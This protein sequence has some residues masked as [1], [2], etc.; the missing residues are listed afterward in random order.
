MPAKSIRGAGILAAIAVGMLVS[1]VLAGK[2]ARAGEVVD[3]VVARVEGDILLL[4]D[5]RELGQFQLLSG[6]KPEPASKRLE[7]LIDQWMI[8]R[9]AR[10]AR[11]EEPAVE[12]ANT[13][14]DQMQKEL[15]G[16]PVFAA[17]LAELGL[18]AAAVR[19]LLRR[20]IFF[21]RYLDYKFRPAVQVDEA[22]ERKYYDDELVPQM[23]ARGEKAPP[24][25][26]VR[27]QIQE[28]LVQRDISARAEKW[29]V[30]S[31]ARLKVEVV[32]PSPRD[33]TV[34]PG[35]ELISPQ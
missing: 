25:D 33:A 31:R 3:R 32:P 29:L 27:K 14:F 28:L 20:A 18:S 5:L 8:E 2:E 6:A 35:S 21:S 22:A 23:T 1:L 16:E 34:G 24:L 7:E 26:S 10:A 11:F 12:D 13:A 15:G 4:S 19:R 9:E 17:R 30:D